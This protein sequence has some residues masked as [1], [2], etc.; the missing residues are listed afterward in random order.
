MRGVTHRV[1]RRSGLFV[2]LAVFAWLFL[3]LV[4][5]PRRRR[6]AAL[7]LVEASASEQGFVPNPE[8]RPA[9]PEQEP[10]GAD[11]DEA[12]ELALV[13]RTRVQ[14]EIGD[15][16]IAP[17]EVLRD[18]EVNDH[19]MPPGILWIGPDVPKQHDGTPRS[20]V[21]HGETTLDPQSSD[22]LPD[23]PD[24]DDELHK[25]L[26][27]LAAPHSGSDLAGDPR[28]I[29]RVQAQAP[30]TG[31][32]LGLRPYLWALWRFRW[33]IPVAVLAAILVPLLMI[34]RPVWPPGLEARETVSYVTRTQ[35]LVDSP[36]RPFFRTETKLLGRSAETGTSASGT[37]A[38]SSSVESSGTQPLVSSAN[39]F[40]LLIESDEVVALRRRLGGVVGTVQATALYSREGVNSFRPSVLP[41]IQI[42]AFAPDAKSAV[43]LGPATAQAFEIWLAQ[44]QSRAG[45]PKGERIVV[46][47]L[48]RPT[49]A[50]RV[51]GPAYGLPLLAGLA[52]LGSFIGLAL[53]TDRARLEVR[54]ERSSVDAEETTHEFPYSPSVRG[55]GEAP[56]KASA[57]S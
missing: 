35:L 31:A 15:P 51:G 17:P 21:E 48:R 4:I 41:V 28:P 30:P 24:L 37:A 33:L 32:Q 6:E 25:L 3:V 43:Q 55:A 9:A 10:D 54:N 52:I 1:S 38:Q 34:Y 7:A 44:E 39:L 42:T 50:E 13:E 53:G 29:A 16:T 56:R 57:A 27:A 14:T 8:P 36:S 26:N 46:Q 12:R 19:E 11:T 5:L 2:L 40:P 47:Q 45:V 20:L 49:S 22:R 18:T 23:M